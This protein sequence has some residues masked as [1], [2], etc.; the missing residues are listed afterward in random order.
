[1]SRPNLLLVTVDCLRADVTRVYGGPARTPAI[2]ALAATGRRYGCAFAHSSFTKTTF[3][4]IFGGSYPSDYGG[5]DRLTTTRPSVV[6]HLRAGGYQTLG[7]NSN[8]WLSSTF[9]FDRGYDRY[10]DLSSATPVAHSLPVRLLNH[11]LGLLGG[12]WVYPP[13]PPA[14]LVTERAMTLLAAARS[15]WF[16]W[17]HY[18]DAHWPYAVERPRPFGPWD[19]TRWAYSPA[20]IRRATRTPSA[21]RTHEREA[22]R[23]LYIAG[24]ERVDGAIGRLL[25]RAGPETAVMLTADHGEAFGE[26]GQYFH[27][28]ALHKENLH[29]PLVVRA[30]GVPAATVEPGIVRHIDLAPTLLQIA[31]LPAEPRFRGVGLLPAAR[32]ENP[33]PSLE[34]FARIA[35]ADGD[36]LSLRRDGWALIARFRREQEGSPEHLRLYHTATDPA[37]S[38]DR[39]T[40]PSAPLASLVARLQ[41]FRD[42]QAAA[43]RSGVPVAPED[44]ELAERL[45]ALGYLE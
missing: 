40:D 38:H 19:R 39:S 9:G 8:P 11:G 23:A 37:E 26:H 17:V 32:D 25:T 18:M 12:G 30:P 7:V 2:D 31:E 14:S 36:W 41:Q 34:A 16:L 35:T 20:L 22:L 10:E 13:Y 33:L 27:A 21:V 42:Q 43:G 3:P 44:P 45:R 1:M 4:T 6:D 24:V 5:S 15:P 29:V 28:H